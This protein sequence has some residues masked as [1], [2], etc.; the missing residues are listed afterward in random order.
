MPMMPMVTIKALLHTPAELFSLLLVSWLPLWHRA[1]CC[2]NLWINTHQ[3]VHCCFFFPSDK[4]WDQP[5]K[6]IWVGKK[7]SSKSRPSRAHGEK[8]KSAWFDHRWWSK[9]HQMGWSWLPSS[10][11][12]RGIGISL[13]RF[14]SFL[15]L[16]SAHCSKAKPSLGPHWGI[17]L[18]SRLLCNYDCCS[19]LVMLSALP[20]RRSWP[21]TSSFASP[22]SSSF[23]A[24]LATVAATTRFPAHTPT[25]QDRNHPLTHLQA[26]ML[27]GTILIP[28]FHH[29]IIVFLGINI[30][31]WTPSFDVLQFYIP[32]NL[33]TWQVHHL[34]CKS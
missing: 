29:Q 8:A 19:F 2:Q 25:Q 1:V 20:A 5:L 23:S 12:R 10:W 33:F 13:H 28:M 11:H 15:L 22:S 31:E 7:I 17:T 6:S 24:E 21:P 26:H 14:V 16:T 9:L 4:V 18:P 32:P 3:G 30:K 34:H 27:S